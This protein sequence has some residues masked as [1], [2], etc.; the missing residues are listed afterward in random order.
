MYHGWFKG[1][2]RLQLMSCLLL[3][4]ARRDFGSYDCEFRK[5]W[6]HS[7][8][9]WSGLMR[10]SAQVWTIRVDIHVL[11]HDGNLV[12]CCSVSSI[13]ALAHFR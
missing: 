11:N 9:R 1:E 5:D 7:T 4:I 13:A 8:V 12:D 3:G 6:H 10:V 2:W